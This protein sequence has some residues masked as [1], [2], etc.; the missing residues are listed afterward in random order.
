MRKSMDRVEDDVRQR[1][2]WALADGIGKLGRRTA[3]YDLDDVAAAP[4]A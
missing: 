3:G 4:S 2:R 1:I